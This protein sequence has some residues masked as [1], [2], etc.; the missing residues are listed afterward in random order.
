MDKAAM[1]GNSVP[2]NSKLDCLYYPF[3]RLLDSNTL[4]YLLLVFDSISFL[5]E[6]RDST[7]RRL[8]LKQMQQTS[9]FFGRFEALADEYR[10]LEESG[11]LRILNPRALTAPDS[12]MVAMA[13]LTDLEDRDL[14]EIASR[15]DRYGL[16]FL[17]HDF[18]TSTQPPRPTWQIFQS[19][20]PS[21]LRGG[22][23][24]AAASAWMP[25]V[26]HR[27]DALQSWSLSY[28]AAA[29]VQS[30]IILRRHRNSD[31]LQSQRANSITS[32]FCA[33]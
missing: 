20:I 23:K 11:V 2:L 28:E 14:L 30:I 25:H 5:D 21:A 19:K 17:P 6:A 16:P 10:M 15:P 18:H 8:L 1:Q 22:N 4:K 24:M 33:N 9:P 32:L 13:V 3:S 12:D 7:W 27:G 26:L 29:C 31:S